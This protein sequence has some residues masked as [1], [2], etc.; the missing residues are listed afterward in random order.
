MQ[1]NSV[2]RLAAR[3][4]SITQ[5]LEKARSLVRRR[6]PRVQAVCAVKLGKVR[7][8]SMCAICATSVGGEGIVGSEVD[9]A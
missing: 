9:M 8:L 6:L 7:E 5:G 4:I 2:C 1:W 3:V